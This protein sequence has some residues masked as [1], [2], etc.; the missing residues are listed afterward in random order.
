MKAYRYPAYAALLCLLTACAT[1][2]FEPVPKSFD[3]RLSA[4]YTLN[5]TLRDAAAS[6]L[7]A[8]AITSD[9]G[10]KALTETR[11]FR[12][13]L[14]QVK[15]LADTDGSTAD[16]RLKVLEA[17]LQALRSELLAKGVKVQP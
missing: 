15:V 7:A 3:G 1:F 13:R 4:A 2:G 8:G 9:D 16:A 12:L 14:D 10:D 5:T 17:A 6:S 11:S